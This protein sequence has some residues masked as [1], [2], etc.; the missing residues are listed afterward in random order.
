MHKYN[1]YIY[2]YLIYC[3]LV[4]WKLLT[5]KSQYLLFGAELGDGSLAEIKLDLKGKEYIIT[6]SLTYFNDLT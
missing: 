6:Y 5:A 3:S 2:I 1:R 4:H